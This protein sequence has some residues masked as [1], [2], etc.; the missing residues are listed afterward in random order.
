MERPHRKL[1]PVQA[2]IGG[3][4]GP[5]K[6][7]ALH[8]GV[9]A[10]SVDAVRAATLG[11][12]VRQPG[13]GEESPMKTRWALTTAVTL[14]TACVATVSGPVRATLKFTKRGVNRTVRD[15]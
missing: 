5:S 7:S 10:S 15:S 12:P 8:S 14:L 9:G 6:N 3:P 13:S 1:H 11:P 4:G 2:E